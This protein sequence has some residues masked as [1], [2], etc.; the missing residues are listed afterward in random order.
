MSKPFD[1]ALRE[2]AKLCL[3]SNSALAAASDPKSAAR[4]RPSHAEL[5]EV[6]EPQ[7][8]AH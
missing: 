5:L 4:F 8:P 6:F 2:L 7:G 1:A 3:K